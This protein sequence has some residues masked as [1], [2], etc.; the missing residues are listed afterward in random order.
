[1]EVVVEKIKMKVVVEEEELD[2]LM[3]NGIKQRVEM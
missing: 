2:P 3:S 1:M